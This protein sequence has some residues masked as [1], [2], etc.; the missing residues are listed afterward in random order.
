LDDNKTEELTYSQ[1]YYILNR[2]KLLSQ[3]REK[4][5]EAKFGDFSA[6]LV[7][8]PQKN[9][10]WGYG[11]SVHDEANQKGEGCFT[12]GELPTLRELINF[13][14]I[15]QMK[16]IKAVNLAALK[17]GNTENYALVCS[18]YSMRHLYMTAKTLIS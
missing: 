18:G 15:Y 1:E 4:E 17:D 7:K 3:R 6:R 16:D 13:L 14:E 8:R 11:T 2:D 12:Q 9:F 5:Q 10:L